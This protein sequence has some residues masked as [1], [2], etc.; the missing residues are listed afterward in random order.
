M[1]GN[2]GLA[3]GPVGLGVYDS[4]R[5]LAAGVDRSASSTSC[6]AVIVS[7]DVLVVGVMSQ[8]ADVGRYGA[9]HRMVSAVMAFGMIFQQVVFP[10]LAR[11]W[12][13]S[14]KDAWSVLA[15]GFCGAGPRLGLDP[16][17]GWGNSACSGKAG[18]GCSCRAVS[19]SGITSGGGHLEGAGVEP[20][21]P[22]TSATLVAMN[23]ESQGVRLLIGGAV[24][25]V[26]LIALLHWC[27]GLVGASMAVL[28][29]GV[30]LVAAGYSCLSQGPCR[31]AGHHH[32]ARP[33]IASA[34]MVP[35]CLRGT[36]R[37]QTSWRP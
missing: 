17:R 32:L 29:I 11:N 4:G 34:V 26:P 36:E 13:A 1:P 16:G 5:F 19:S 35:V 22:C 12:R 24:V 37:V 3:E 9:P 21:L 33:L 20:G 18:R 6:Q 25:S 14:P 28:V 2:I 15:S 30:G 31:P 27:F 8:W 10:A 7:A 23:R